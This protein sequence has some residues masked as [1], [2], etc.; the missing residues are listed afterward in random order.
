MCFWQMGR[1]HAF[2]LQ[3]GHMVGDENIFCGAVVLP[4]VNVLCPLAQW[5]PAGG[6]LLP[7]PLSGQQPANQLEAYITNV[8]PVQWL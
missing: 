8:A 6:A 7:M 3:Q 4:I 5:L 2:I 1:Q